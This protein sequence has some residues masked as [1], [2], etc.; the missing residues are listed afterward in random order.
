MG[1]RR[2][3]PPPDAAGDGSALS[4]AVGA[5]DPEALLAQIDRG[6][7]PVVVDVRSGV[8]FRRGHVPG[9]MHLPFWLAFWGSGDLGAGL[10]D[11]VVLYCG[12]GPRA[13][14]AGALLR[15]RGFRNVCCL[16]G[17]MAGWKG[18]GFR[19]ER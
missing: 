8:E 9:A 19:Q 7:P 10:D 15:A 11:P 14:M 2:G 16:R 6:R 3:F 12:R 1:R 4:R 5:I 18:R 17:H 13:W